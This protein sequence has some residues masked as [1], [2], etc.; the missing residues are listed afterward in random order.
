MVAVALV[1]LHMLFMCAVALIVLW[2]STV[3]E[4]ATRHTNV[5]LPEISERILT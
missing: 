4:H 1:V 3:W 2:C 5:P